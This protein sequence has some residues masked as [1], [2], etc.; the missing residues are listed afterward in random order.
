MVGLARMLLCPVCLGGFLFLS[1][2][3]KC[4]IPPAPFFGLT[5][6]L[7]TGRDT[8]SN[9]AAPRCGL[10][11]SPW[12]TE[13]PPQ[14]LGATQNTQGSLDNHTVWRDHQARSGLNYKIHLQ[15]TTSP[16]LP[17]LLNAQKPTQRVKENEAMKEYVANKRIM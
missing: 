2:Q 3:A 17:L 15:Q 11:P 10:I 4:L 6:T 8:G 7:C 5:N 16:K 12:D 13:M 14:R 1:N 9:Q